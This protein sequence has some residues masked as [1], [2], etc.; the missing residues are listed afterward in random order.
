MYRH[1]AEVPMHYVPVHVGRGLA[2][3]LPSHL[4]RSY[5]Q[6]V[7]HRLTGSAGPTG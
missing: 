7:V 3:V 1:T 6:V 5:R 2:N 4:I